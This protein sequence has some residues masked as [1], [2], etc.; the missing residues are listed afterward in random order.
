M[1]ANDLT[2][3]RTVSDFTCY[4][5][6]SQCT[7]HDVCMEWSSEAV[8]ADGSLGKESVQNMTVW[9]PCTLQTLNKMMSPMCV[10]DSQLYEMSGGLIGYD[11]C[12]KGFDNGYT[13]FHDD[14]EHW[15]NATG[16]SYSLMKSAQW[17]TV[18]NGRCYSR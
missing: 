6:Q 12:M 9:K 17:E 1:L 8:G 15:P 11:F 4:G 5:V 10:F 18:I 2:I 13:N 16:Y 14:F 7:D 3:P